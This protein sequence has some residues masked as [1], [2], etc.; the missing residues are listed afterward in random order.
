MCRARSI[1]SDRTGVRRICRTVSTDS[2]SISRHTANKCGTCPITIKIFTVALSRAFVVLT[3]SGNVTPVFTRSKGNGGSCPTDNAAYNAL[4]ANG[5]IVGRCGDRVAGISGNTAHYAVRCGNVPVCSVVFVARFSVNDSPTDSTN[6]VSYDTT[7]HCSVISGGGVRAKAAAAD[8][9]FVDCIL[10]RS[11]CPT[12]TT[13]HIGMPCYVSGVLGTGEIAICQSAN[14]A[15]VRARFAFDCERRNRCGISGGSGEISYTI[16]Y[17]TA[18]VSSRMICPTC[19][20][21]RRCRR[22]IC[23]IRTA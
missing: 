18:C 16:S 5:T 4:T 19:I 22:N 3:C 7:G 11:V 13:T 1:S 9:S 10:K 20:K 2:G 12:D 6:T 8:F 17:V 15:D 23:I 21:K 14:A